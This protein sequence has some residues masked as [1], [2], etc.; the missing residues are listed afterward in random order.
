MP[1]ANTLS[2]HISGM[3]KDSLTTGSNSV[4]LQKT[5]YR[6]GP[7]S[8]SPKEIQKFG[9]SDCTKECPGKGFGAPLQPQQL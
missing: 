3:L 1:D 2:W 5:S 6:Y 4:G 9:D 8:F 7:P